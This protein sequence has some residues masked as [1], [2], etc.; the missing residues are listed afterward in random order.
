[1]HAAAPPTWRR[2]R[3]DTPLLDCRTGGTGAGRVAV[4][5]AGIHAPGRQVV[6]V[7]AVSGAG[8]AARRER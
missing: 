7:R 8:P 6:V 5:G 3:A 4:R 2:D 1:M